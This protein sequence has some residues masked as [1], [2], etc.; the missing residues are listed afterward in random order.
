MLAKTTQYSKVAARLLR[1]GTSQKNHS[2]AAQSIR[3]TARDGRFKEFLGNMVLVAVVLATLLA[4]ILG[5]LWLKI[6]AAGFVA[7]VILLSYLFLRN[8]MRGR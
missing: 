5:P 1:V 4:I 6:V 8:F 3:P 7:L 2:Y